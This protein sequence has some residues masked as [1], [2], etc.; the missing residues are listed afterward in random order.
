MFKL[1]SESGRCRSLSLFLVPGAEE[2]SRGGRRGV[3]HLKENA[4]P[5]DPTAG[6]C[7][8]S[9]GG[10]RGVGIFIWARYPCRPQLVLRE[11][12]YEA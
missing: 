11:C 1:I 3:P 8:G 10:S 4:P 6:L 2:R 5:Q 9:S 12:A 7:L